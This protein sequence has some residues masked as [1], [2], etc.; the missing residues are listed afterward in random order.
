MHR[1]PVELDVRQIP[2]ALRL[3]VF[4][5]DKGHCV[6]CGAKIVKGEWQ[7]DHVTRWSDGGRTELRNLQTLCLPCHAVKTRTVDTPGAAKT[8]RMTKCLVREPDEIPVSRLRGKGFDKT[9][10]RG[11]DRIVRPRKDKRKQTAHP[12][13]TKA[14]AAE[15]EPQQNSTTEQP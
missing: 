10:T 14:R 1:D 15:G 4:D 7:C 9:K 11:F 2:K 5:R 8:K 3:K 6:L 13:Q 12:S